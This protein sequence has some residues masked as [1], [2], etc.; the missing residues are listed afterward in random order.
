MK[1]YEIRSL[2]LN[3]VYLSD[4]KMEFILNIYEARKT[5]EN[6]GYVGEETGI[7]ILHEFESEAEA[8]KARLDWLEEHHHILIDSLCDTPMNKLPLTC[9]EIMDSHRN[10]PKPTLIIFAAPDGW[11]IPE[12]EG[13][14]VKDGRKG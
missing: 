9:R 7:A 1:Q 8:D 5:D 4:P 3:D 12:V 14:V 10:P 11:E 13:Y 2:D 6:D